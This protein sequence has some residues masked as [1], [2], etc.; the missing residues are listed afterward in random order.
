M[1]KCYILVSG[2]VFGIVALA[3]ASRALMQLPVHIGSFEIPVWASWVA[4][5]VAGGLCAWAFRS[6]S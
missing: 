2:L 1:S 5:A 4:S 6:K 3:Q